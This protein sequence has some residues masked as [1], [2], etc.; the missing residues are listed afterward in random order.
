[1]KKILLI[2][3]IIVSFILAIIP[4]INAITDSPDI[5]VILES[6]SP[7]PV[8]PGQ[9]F[10]VKFKIENE[11]SQTT[12]DVIVRV[13]PKYPFTI[14][15]DDEEKNIGKLRASTTGADAVEVEFQLKVDEDAVEEETELELEI[16]IIEGSTKSYTNNNF[17]IDIQTHDA[18][19]EITS[20]EITPEKVAPGETAEVKL[21]IKNQ[22]DSLLKDIVFKLEMSSSTIPFA[23]YQS[24]SEKRIALLNS[25]YQKSL[26]FNLITS[27]DADAGLY[28][29]PLNITYNDEKG[30]SYSSEDLLAIQIGKIPVL[31]AYVKKTEILQSGQAGKVTLEIANSDIVDVN[32]LELELIESSEYLLVDPSNYFY[33]GDLDADDTESEEINIYVPGDIEEVSIPI[34]LTYTDDNNQE[35]QQTF[36]LDLN[37]YSYGE[38]KKYGLTQSS[39]GG[40]WIVIVILIIAGVSYYIYRKRKNQKN[41]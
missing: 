36:N 1:M 6:Q 11:G 15:G 16:E 10:K 21:M 14:Y 25:G 12:E 5:N 28:K 31:K 20:V 38:L 37:L 33:L 35:Y 18:I 40:Y 13:L 29:V 24:G 39:S 17:L 9:T 32:N 30:N 4:A 34:K 41:D 2:I 8:E 23:P 22:A 7:D 27:P 19:L 3:L 26:T